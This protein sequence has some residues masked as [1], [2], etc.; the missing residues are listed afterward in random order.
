MTSHKISPD[1]MFQKKGLPFSKKRVTLGNSGFTLVEIL[2]VIGIFML[3]AALTLGVGVDTA[4]RATVGSERTTLVES[5]ER[6]RS[7]AMN[8]LGEKQHGVIVTS[9]DFVL[10]QG[11]IYS[12]GDPTNEVSERSDG[13]SVTGPTDPVTVVF[14]QLSGRV[15]AGQTGDI[16]LSNGDQNATVGIN[17]E[18]RIDW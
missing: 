15:D 7:R 13:I 8:N 6:A 14:A 4:R 9:T 17:T 12:A 1:N 16:L 11:S 5:L 18:G 10:F 3:L 2:I